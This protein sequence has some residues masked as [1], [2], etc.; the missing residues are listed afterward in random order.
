VI[1][2]EA[3]RARILIVDDDPDVRW[4]TAEALRDRYV[5]AAAATSGE[6]LA[7]AREQVPGAIVVDVGLGAESG[8]ELIRA[9]QADATLRPV[10]VAVL[11]ARVLVPPPGVAP[12][13][14]YLAKPCPMTRLRDVLEQLL[15]ADSARA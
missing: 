7:L 11:S 4:M 6:A 14:A 12:C 8:W 15:S 5:V 1:A 2:S 13:A 10:P 9:L 3:S